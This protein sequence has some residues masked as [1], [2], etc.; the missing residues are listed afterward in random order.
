MNCNTNKFLNHFFVLWWDG[1]VF[2][3]LDL[4][5]SLI[6]DVRVLGLICLTRFGLCVLVFFEVGFH[7]EYLGRWGLWVGFVLCTPY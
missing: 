3:F 7:L 6:D 1:W 2:Y 5:L 4:L